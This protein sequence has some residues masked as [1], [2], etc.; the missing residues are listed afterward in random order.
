MDCNNVNI[1]NTI[2]IIIVHTRLCRASSALPM[3][4]SMVLFT[5]AGIL[6]RHFVS[7]CA[8]LPLAVREEERLQCLETN[9]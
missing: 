6:G 7:W 4:I 9:R 8:V 5:E 1:F 3:Y 2:L